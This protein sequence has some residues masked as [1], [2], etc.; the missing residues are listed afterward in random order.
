L[1]QLYQ[2]SSIF[3]PT[4]VVSDQKYRSRAAAEAGATV[5]LLVPNAAWIDRREHG[6]VLNRFL[7]VFCGTTVAAPI[8]DPT[9]PIFGHF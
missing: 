8:I 9:L 5:C 1:I 4:L 2:Y 6:I 3:D 7:E